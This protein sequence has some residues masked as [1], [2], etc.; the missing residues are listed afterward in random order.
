MLINETS[1]VTNL[2]KKAIEYYIEQELVFPTILENG[3]RKFSEEDIEQL[4]KISIFRKLG[5]S[6]EEA[7]AVL[8]DETDDTLQ[9]LLVQKELNIQREQ[10]KK[11]IMDKLCCGKEYSEISM[12][13]EVIEKGATV[14]EKL[15]DAFPGYYGRFICLHFAQ[16]LNEPITTAE[17][18]SA[19]R[20]IIGFLDNVPSLSFPEDLQIFLIEST[21]HIGTKDI[22]DIIEN[23]KQSIK[24]PE[25]FLSENK[26]F[27]EQYIEFKQSDQY[28]NSPVYKI[29]SLMKEFN[30]SIGYYD[31]FIPAMKKL[32][33]SY[34]NYYRQMEL[35]GEK[36][37]SQYPDIEK[38]DR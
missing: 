29:Q 15:I 20:E 8:A 35:A 36:L 26:C 33:I 5:L 16:F 21:K 13:I 22:N 34:A 19:Y 12:D 1:K 3:Y 11:V 23:T 9:K 38:L 32:S 27:L 14:T 25:K 6:I 7:K 2:T 4:K 10:A 30:K 37:L 18:Q 24:N 28:K 17:Q 31:I